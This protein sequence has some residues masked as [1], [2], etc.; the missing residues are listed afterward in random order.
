MLWT[1][2]TANMARETNKGVMTC[3]K[4]IMAN[5]STIVR[6][7][8]EAITSLAKP[9][10][11]LEASLHISQTTWTL[12]SS[13]T[14][15]SPSLSRL[16][17][18]GIILRYNRYW[19]STVLSYIGNSAGRCG[20]KNTTGKMKCTESRNFV[21]VIDIIKGRYVIFRDPNIRWKMIVEAMLSK[22]FGACSAKNMTKW[23]FI[24][25]RTTYVCLSFWPFYKYFYLVYK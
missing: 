4:T 13:N 24:G 5:L 19:W 20:G 10:D 21:S 16:F 25:V 17:S 2:K 1:S 14:F 18:F 12:T 7:L 9:K 22:S 3:C 8:F 23:T 15:I 6:L 11:S